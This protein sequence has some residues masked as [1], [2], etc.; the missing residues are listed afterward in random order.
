MHEVLVVNRLTRYL[1]RGNGLLLLAHIQKTK[2]K[3]PSFLSEPLHT[4]GGRTHAAPRY[5]M[6]SCT[7]V[8]A[9]LAPRHA[10]RV[11]IAQTCM[12]AHSCSLTGLTAPARGWGHVA[13][14]CLLFCTLMRNTHSAVPTS[15]CLMDTGAH[16]SSVVWFRLY[17][18]HREQC[19]CDTHI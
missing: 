12:H 2:E 6:L 11:Q 17:T 8:R 10:D 7:L 14:M 15:G 3:T 4:C 5:P 1:N 13:S 18:A 16:P 9:H 19:V